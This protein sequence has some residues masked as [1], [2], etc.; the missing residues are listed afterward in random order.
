[1]TPPAALTLLLG[2]AAAA[3]AAEPARRDALGDPLPV[4]AVARLG[5]ARFRHPGGVANLAF[6]PDGKRFATAGADSTIRVWELPD[7]RPVGVLRVRLSGARAFA[8]TP[9][10]KA[11]V[12]VDAGGGLS[13]RDA[14]TGRELRRLRDESEPPATD[15]ALSSYG[16]TL[17][18]L[19]GPGTLVLRD[20]RADREIARHEGDGAA[21]GPIRFTADG[22]C[23]AWGGLLLDTASGKPAWEEMERP[24][25][26]EIRCRTLSTDGKR[27]AGTYWSFF[28]D[29]SS[30]LFLWDAATGKCGPRLFVS[31]RRL[32][33]VAFAPDGKTLAVSDEDG[34]VRLLDAETGKEAA[35]LAGPPEAV[36][37]LEFA[38]DGK[39]LAAASGHGQLRLWDLSGGERA[40]FAGLEGR[41]TGIAFLGDGK[42]IATSGFGVRLWDA[43][44]GRPLRTL[45]DMGEPTRDLGATPDGKLVGAVTG[46]GRFVAWETAGGSPRFRLNGAIYGATFLPD[47][48][49]FLILTPNPEVHDLRDGE[50]S[51]AL[52]GAAQP[53]CN[54]LAGGPD[55][56][57]AESGN[58]GIRLRDVRSGQVLKHFAEAGDRVWAEAGV[59]RLEFAPGGGLLALGCADG[60]VFLLDVVNGT[61]R[62]SVPAPETKPETVALAFTPDGRTLA[63]GRADGTVALWEVA[64]DRERGLL[65]SGESVVVGLAFSPDGRRL[66][67]AHADE[68]PLVW[69]LLET[70]AAPDAE[71]TPDA[72]DRLWDDLGGADAVAAR[73]AVPLLARRPERGVPFLRERLKGLK[74]TALDRLPRW[75]ADLDSDD[76]EA[77][78]RATRELR[79]LGELAEPALRQALA[80]DPP[81]EARRRLQTLLAD[82]RTG[83]GI[84]DPTYLRVQ[85]SLEALELSGSAEARR[86]I[87]ALAAG[88][89]DSWLAGE[90]KAARQRGQRRP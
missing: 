7:G 43:A 51:H 87:D 53:G 77:R 34:V 71:L 18:Y 78:E 48:K 26:G 84:T 5:S 69:D 21:S 89:A 46:E 19:C 88:P 64:T 39:T 16:A 45:G 13:W 80:D 27:L 3:P 59:V 58:D 30:S 38:S 35:R 76:F 56:T 22:K 54:A 20:L 86:L 33:A 57:F 2:L 82:L 40:A 28:D 23:V 62:R 75:L 29:P 41:P 81:L 17:A 52:E 25:G 15:V 72:L 85:R 65:R 31:R 74:Q 36:A 42:V 50:L 8:F 67:V 11:L 55:G 73:R 70:D 32:D 6:S 63:V 47:G 90:A 24:G 66:A 60:A 10:G 9:D 68:P 61:V 37:R 83:G 4:G 44:T 1:M 79:R 12:V 49:R 14:A